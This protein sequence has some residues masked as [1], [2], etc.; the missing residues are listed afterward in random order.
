MTSDLQLAGL[1]GTSRST[2]RFSSGL[3]PIRL[4][5]TNARGPFQGRTLMTKGLFALLLAGSLMVPHITPALGQST[6][7]LAA[8]PDN[9]SKE[10][11]EA[12]RLPPVPYLEGM[13]WLQ[14]GAALSEP[15]S[16]SLIGPKLDTLGP[17]LLQPDI[18]PTRFTSN[19]KPFDPRITTE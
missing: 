12:L 14:S 1:S 11:Y 16:D 2:T 3:G 4:H 10:A 13:P 15:K 17:F 7:G 6:V 19:S 18:P 9:A 8:R 5:E